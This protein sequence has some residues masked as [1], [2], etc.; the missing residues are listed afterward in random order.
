MPRI[1]LTAFE[2][3]GPWKENSS[4]LALMELT[5]WFDT[6]GQVVTRR[7]PVNLSDMVHRLGE[8][9]L[10]GFD[11]AL[12]LGQSPG[13][14]AIKLESTGMNLTTAGD[15]IIPDA[16]VAF[17][18]NLPLNQW[19][20]RL[21]GEGI[22]A[23]VSHHAGEQICNAA[24][25]Y[26]QHYAHTRGMSTQSCFLHLPLTP[27]QAAQR[28]PDHHPLPSMNLN[29]MASGLAIILGELLNRNASAA[30]ES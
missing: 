3:Y 19:A 13:A 10:L 7:Y 2:P 22:P 28:L 18:T 8:D 30:T 1:L 14:P 23:I 15:T 21:C 4:W 29:V 24:L 12:H 25:F 26:S 11:Y 20:T 17:R 16:A 5:R 6:G 9:L 27:Q